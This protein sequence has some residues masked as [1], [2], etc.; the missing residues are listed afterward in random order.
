MKRNVSWLMGALAGVLIGLAGCGE[1]PAD[2]AGGSQPA[3]APA[4]GSGVSDKLARLIKEGKVKEYTRCVARD[5][6]LGVEAARTMLP[7]G[8]NCDGKVIWT[9]QN[10]GVP[11]I[12]QISAQ[13]PDRRQNMVYL[14]FLSFVE[15]LHF[16]SGGITLSQ[17]QLYREGQIG[18]NGAPMLKL[19]P[20]AD[21]DVHMLKKIYPGIQDIKIFKTT[22]PTA[23]EREQ[24]AQALAQLQAQMTIN[25]PNPSGL[26]LRNVKID[27]ALIEATATQNGK[28]Y[29]LA[30]FAFIQSSEAGAQNSRGGV[31]NIMWNASDILLYTAEPEVYDAEQATLKLFKANYARNQQWDTALAQASAQLTEQRNARSRQ[32]TQQTIAQLNASH[33]RAQAAV[34]SMQQSYASTQE[35]IQRRSNVQSNVLAGATDAIVGRDNYRAPDGGVMK[36]DSRFDRVYEGTNSYNNGRIIATQGVELDRNNYK[37]LQKLPSVLP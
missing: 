33:A 37:E 8:W 16:R 12:V 9:E 27:F 32:Q 20:P 25:G 28:P 2:V 5:D 3:G 35:S 7:A 31:A 1:S 24:L 30:A 17:A 4:T 14:S 10:G 18:D 22:L 15:P 23:Q 11:A 21:F 34:K 13:A 36:V 26:Y 6:S 19:M 29:K